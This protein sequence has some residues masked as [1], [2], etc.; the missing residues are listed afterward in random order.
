[1]TRKYENV[2]RRRCRH[3]CTIMSTAKTSIAFSDH[4]QQFGSVSASP[5][6]I[7]EQLEAKDILATDT[8]CDEHS[9]ECW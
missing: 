9:V 8:N 6:G 2:I 1:M 4:S 7:L 3:Y 5:T